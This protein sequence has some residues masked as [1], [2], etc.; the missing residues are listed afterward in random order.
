MNNEIAKKLKEMFNNYHS[1]Q[2]L[3]RREISISILSYTEG[4]CDSIL[5]TNN[6]IIK[7]DE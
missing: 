5:K 1:S 3:F 4:I 6:T 2:G 7:N